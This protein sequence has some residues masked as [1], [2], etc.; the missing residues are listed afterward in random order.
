MI[1]VWYYCIVTFD[2]YVVCTHT[3]INIY[4]YIVSYYMYTFWL[5]VLVVDSSHSYHIISISSSH[6][7]G[8]WSWNTS[9][10]ANC[11]STWWRRAAC[12]SPWQPAW[13]GRWLQRWRT[14]T[15]TAWCIG[16]SNRSGACWWWLG[17]A[18]QFG[19]G[20]FVIT[21]VIVTVIIVIIARMIM[22]MIMIMWGFHSHGGTPIF[23]IHV[24]LGFFH[25]INQPACLGYPHFG[26]PPS[27]FIGCNASWRTVWC[28]TLLSPCVTVST[29][30]LSGMKHQGRT[31]I[32]G[33]HFG[34]TC[35]SI[36]QRCITVLDK[37]K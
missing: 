9:R 32:C 8:I 16:I 33:R 2:I 30:L 11:S 12:R 36:W 1:T 21:I 29:C 3:Y 7:P 13:W 4:I 10:E 26:K 14:A 31:C 34:V 6:Q 24:R 27:G 5:Q 18:S 17:G 28:G 20:E 22:M 37:I 35:P 25:E 15:S 23:I 19:S